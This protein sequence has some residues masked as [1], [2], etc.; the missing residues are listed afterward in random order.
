MRGLIALVLLILCLGTLVKTM[1]AYDRD[2]MRR[3]HAASFFLG[4]AL[5]CS[6]VWA[7]QS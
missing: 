4:I 7:V 6:L 1:W 5:M 3:R 2:T